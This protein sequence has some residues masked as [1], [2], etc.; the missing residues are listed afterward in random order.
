MVKRIF[1]TWLAC[2]ALEVESLSSTGMAD[3]TSWPMFRGSPGLTGISP[4]T[5]PATLNLSWTYKTAGPIKSS[6]AIVDD[7]VFIG[8]DDQHLHAIN[9]KTGQK[10]WSFKTSGPI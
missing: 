9:L 3:K 1:V 10:L 4:A 8:S 5:L 2:F 7:R 6:A